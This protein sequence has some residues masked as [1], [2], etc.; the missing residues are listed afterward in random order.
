MFNLYQAEINC[1]FCAKGF[2]FTWEDEI[3]TKITCPNCNA[4]IFS[5]ESYKMHGYIYIFSNPTMPDLFKIGQTTRTPQ[6]RITEISSTT[7]V[8]E[9]FV[10]EA[11]FPSERPSED[12]GKIHDYLSDKRHNKSREFF[13]GS[14]LEMY[15]VCSAVTG[16][17][18]LNFSL[19]FP[20]T[21]KMAEYD[22]W[23][24]L[25][26]KNV[27]YIEKEII[28]VVPTKFSPRIAIGKGKNNFICVGCE[29]PMRPVKKLLQDRNIF[30]G[31]NECLFFVD[32]YGTEVDLR[33]NKAPD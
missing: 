31:C 18:S 10:I 33:R 3:P 26:G 27:V 12:E 22:P 2:S 25:R 7:G 11:Y 5:Y 28:K 23:L 16:F 24:F 9:N 30:R 1:I 13:S 4:V 6:D 29:K 8:A 15:K 32:Q 14:F 21:D 17:E 20:G 19:S